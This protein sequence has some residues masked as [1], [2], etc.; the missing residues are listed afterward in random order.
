MRTLGHP[1]RRV[2]RYVYTAPLPAAIAANFL[3]LL[4]FGVI[5]YWP[6]I[7]ASSALRRDRTVPGDWW[8]VADGS[9]LP[10]GSGRLPTSAS[11]VRSR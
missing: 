5:F 6:F 8:R 3:F 11:Q 7:V 1:V 9:H 4:V 10:A 2:S